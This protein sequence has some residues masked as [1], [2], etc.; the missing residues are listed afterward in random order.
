M[1]FITRILLFTLCITLS[2]PL[3]ADRTNRLAENLS[4]LIP[5]DG[6]AI[7]S[8]RLYAKT[9]MDRLIQDLER[10]K[11]GQRSSKKVA[12]ILE[13]YI[14]LDLLK[15]H[16]GFAPFETL[17]K[18]GHYSRATAVA[19]YALVAEEFG[20]SYQIRNEL[21]AINITLDP[22]GRNIR[23]KIPRKSKSPVS[24]QAF[25]RNYLDL[26]RASKLVPDE[27][28]QK[29]EQ[30]IFDK[31]YYGAS[32]ELSFR[33][34]AGYLQYLQAL[35]QYEKGQYSEA[36]SHTERAQDLYDRPVHEVLRR[37]ILL[38]IAAPA[39]VN[40]ERISNVSGSSEALYYLFQLWE[41]QPSD[42]LRNSLVNR[43]A[44]VA[45]QFL[46]KQGQ[47]IAFDSIHNYFQSKISD[48]PDLS[49]QVKEIFFLKKASYYAQQ[50]RT[51]E[52]MEYTDSLYRYRPNDPKVH[53]VLSGLLT[54]SL[55]AQKD[56]EQGLE[57]LIYYQKR[58]PFLQSQPV[59]QDFDL[60]YRAEQL[61]AIFDADQGLEGTRLLREFESL[62]S[63]YG[64]TPRHRSWITTAYY[65]ASNFYFRKM[66]YYNAL[67]MIERANNLA[68]NDAF[69]EHRRSVLRN[70]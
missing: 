46:L 7:Q 64:P 58:Y 35:K 40:Y 20:L 12:R 19:L 67:Q 49:A 38:Q 15:E 28:W 5:G 60:Y 45:D 27:D 62:L 66:D 14:T 16:K 65:A 42:E 52:V 8:A 57:S 3:A 61:R 29:S 18:Q 4:L 41:E 47:G 30:A 63:R 36:L 1:P 50:G 69:L 53:D 6:P 10:E 70:Y 51:A 2:L 13:Q 25:M 37:A 23:L 33:Q 24:N 68:P 31:Y 43:F 39:P 9:Q 11:V 59:L 54:W 17:L 22:D 56:W 32:D 48:Y 44:Q 55:G 26:L 21:W 34:L